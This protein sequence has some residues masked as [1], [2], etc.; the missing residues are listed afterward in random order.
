[1]ITDDYDSLN[2]S[3]NEETEGNEATDTGDTTKGNTNQGTKTIKPP[4][5]DDKFAQFYTLKLNKNGIEFG[6]LVLQR[7]HEGIIFNCRVA[8]FLM[9]Q[10]VNSQKEIFGRKGMQHIIAL[11]K[12]KPTN[13]QDQLKFS[14][15]LLNFSKE[16]PN[17]KIGSIFSVF[18][19]P[20]F[21]LLDEVITNELRCYLKNK[22]EFYKRH[23]VSDR[24][25][26][27]D[28]DV[29]PQSEYGGATTQYSP[30]KKFT[31]VDDT[32]T[33]F[34]MTPHMNRFGKVIK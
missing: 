20:F 33:I 11:L 18:I 4:D 8:L 13:L 17:L 16:T 30:D 32:K 12:Y 14:N 6:D 3:D 25:L 27:D 15:I 24:D 10:E 34:V 1:M 21:Y 26:D 31:Y 19:D 9:C 22:Y 5:V 28:E 7:Q 23:L 29:D 2:N